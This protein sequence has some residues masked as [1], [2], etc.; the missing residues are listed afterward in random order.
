[1]AFQSVFALDVLLVINQF[2][3]T[4]SKLEL[5]HQFKALICVCVFFFLKTKHSLTKYCA[6]QIVKDM[7]LTIIIYA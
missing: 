4:K 6:S 5:V 1:M 2:N 3:L 7:S